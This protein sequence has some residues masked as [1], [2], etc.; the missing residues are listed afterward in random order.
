MPISIGIPKEIQK[1][2]NRVSI[3]PDTV[4]VLVKDGFEVLV[5]KGA[6]A[7]S[8]LSDEGFSEAGATIVTKKASFAADIVAKV[9]GPEDKEIALLKKNTLLMGFLKPLDNPDRIASLAK[10][11]ISAFSMEMV[12]RITRAQKMDALSA[13][14]SIA[15]YKAVLIAADILPKYFPLMTTAAGTIRPAKVLVLGAGV[16]GL[17]AIATARRLGAVVSAYD[18]RPAVKE[19]VESLGAKFVELELDTQDAAESSGY[20][21]ALAE[22]KQKRQIELLAKVIS[23]SDVVIS[24]ALIPGRKAPILISEEALINMRAGSVVIDMA[25]ANGGN[26]ELTTAG[27]LTVVHGVFLNG[28]TNL[29]STMPLHASQLYSKTLLAALKEIIQDGVINLDFENEIIAS[30]CLTRDG[31]VVNERINGILSGK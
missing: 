31:Q 21:K 10:K 17:Q 25:A 8:F 11:G 4:S 24:T 30:A 22:D 15:G 13:M 29:P 14:S 3:N 23:G 26:C 2:E 16:A 1:G 7:L 19:E 28:H 12:P 20:A 9:N 18:V 27:E 5:E 6:G